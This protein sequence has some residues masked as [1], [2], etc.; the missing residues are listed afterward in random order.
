MFYCPTC[1]S[2]VAQTIVSQL[3]SK[4][5]DAALHRLKHTNPQLAAALQIV[6]PTAVVIAAVWA[7]PK[8]LR[9]LRA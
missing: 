2:W 4:E 3:L 5:T 6:A 1:A 9:W 8:I 7:T